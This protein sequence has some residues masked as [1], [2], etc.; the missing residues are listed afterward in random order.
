M[1]IFVLCDV[2]GVVVQV[3]VEIIG[4]VFNYIMLWVKDIIV[5]LDFYICV[6]GYQLIDKC[7]FFEV[8]FSL[9]FL[10]YVLVGVVV[11]ED[12]SQCCVW[13]VGLLGVLELIY[14]YGIEIQDG[15][16]YYDGNSDLCGFGYICVLVLDIEVVC[17]CFEDFGVIF[18]K[19]LIDGCMKNLVFIK[20]LDGYWVEIIVNV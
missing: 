5:L 7:D 2:F 18:Q 15:V 4:F 19:C 17:Q 14:N 6:F 9:Y 11:L 1:I 10:V 13:M 20:D 8:Q 12:D 3:L 16:V